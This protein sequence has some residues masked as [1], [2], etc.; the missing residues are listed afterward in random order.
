MRLEDAIG[1]EFEGTD[2]QKYDQMAI[3]LAEWP[4][5]RRVVAL[6]QA[7]VDLLGEEILRLIEMRRDAAPG[8]QGGD[9]D[10]FVREYGAKLR[11]LHQEVMAHVG[12]EGNA[13]RSPLAR[14]IFVDFD[15]FRGHRMPGRKERSV[16]FLGPNHLR[17]KVWDIRYRYIF[18]DLFEPLSETHKIYMLVSNPPEFAMEG[19]A[20]LHERFGVTTIGFTVPNFGTDLYRRW[21]DVSYQVASAVR[22]DVVTNVQG[23]ILFGYVGGILARYLGCR[24]IMRSAGDEIA[25]R[26]EIGSYSGSSERLLRDTAREILAI[27]SSSAVIAMSEW[28]RKRLDLLRYTDVPIEVCARGIDTEAF[29]PVERPEAGKLSVLF[30]GRRSSEKGFDIFER[31]AQTLK[32]EDFEFVI[33][34]PDFDGYEN[35]DMVNKGFVEPADLPS[36]YRNGHILVVPSRSESLGQVVIEAMSCGLPIVVLHPQFRDWLGDDAGIVVVEGEDALAEQCRAFQRCPELLES[37]GVE[38]RAAAVRHFDRRTLGQE[39]RRVVLGQAEDEGPASQ[40]ASGRE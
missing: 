25:A 29:S 36:L 13:V 12:A 40:Q 7:A 26:A 20:E 21:L 31:L 28:E 8:E 39:Y 34:G 30:V 11:A 19:F 22:P 33:A 1:A 3:A 9:Y 37:R 10:Q 16:L 27:N 38:A 18:P 14:K 24:S 5:E 17:P 35:A 2:R 4:K 6:A 15:E 32:G 23:G